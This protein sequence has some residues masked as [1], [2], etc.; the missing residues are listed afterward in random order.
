MRA[1]QRSEKKNSPAALWQCMPWCSRAVC[2]SLCLAYAWSMTCARFGSIARRAYGS[3][4]MVEN[5]TLTCYCPCQSGYVRRSRD[6][7]LCDPSTPSLCSHAAHCVTMK[8]RCSAVY[9]SRGSLCV[10][11]CEGWLSLDQPAEDAEDGVNGARDV[12]GVG[13]ESVDESVDFHGSTPCTSEV[14]MQR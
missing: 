3:M 12:V 7:P 8:Q 11:G 10:R 6:S 13:E 4:R 1:S 2:S 5:N 9:A 14:R